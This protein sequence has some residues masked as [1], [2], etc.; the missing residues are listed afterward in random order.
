MTLITTPFHSGVYGGSVH[1]AMTDLIKLMSKLVDSRGK[2]LIP[3]ILDSVAPMTNEEEK[4]YQAIDFDCHEF[5]S[6]VGTSRLI[7][8]DKVNTLT[9]RWVSHFCRF[10]FTIFNLLL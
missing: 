3:G 9:H 4:I 10:V 5:R 8:D 7:H 2:I 6:D 1:E